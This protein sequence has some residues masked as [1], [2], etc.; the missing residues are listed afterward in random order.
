M[1]IIDKRQDAITLRSLGADNKQISDIFMM[2][3]RMICLAGAVIGIAIGLTLCLLQQQYGF[4]GL[5]SSSG[6]YIINA[7]PVSVH[8]LDLL[9][10]FATVIAVGFISVWYPVRRLSKKYVTNS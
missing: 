7:Y 4:I 6:S 1:L 8:L 2:E 10:I 9:I 5:G 3:G